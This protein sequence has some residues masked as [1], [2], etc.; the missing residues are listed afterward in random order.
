[1]SLIYV[2]IPLASEEH[3]SPTAVISIGAGM[4]GFVVIWETF[5]G[6]EKEAGVF[7]SWKGRAED[8][9]VV[10]DIGSSKKKVVQVETPDQGNEIEKGVVEE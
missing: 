4:S 3:L 10:F 1:M 8:L 2:L 7:E 9:G 6:L 5:T